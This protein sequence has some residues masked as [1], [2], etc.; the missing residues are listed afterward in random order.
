MYDPKTG[1]YTPYQTCFGSHHLQFGYDANETLW[2][3]GARDVAGWI[4]T[5]L[6]DETGDIKKAQGWSPF[7][8][9]TSGDGKRGE[10]TQP[11]K[12]EEPGK[13]KRIAGGFYAVMPSPVDGSVWGTFRGCPGSVVRFVPGAD[14]THTG[15]AEIYH[16]PMPG[17]GPRGGDIDKQGV[18]WVSLA[19]G[20]MGAFDRRK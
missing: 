14:P 6:L 17:F 19:S 9:D 16:V 7:I 13:D 18:V 20:H 5:K 3:S 1:K 10:Y 8:L 11:G 2:T 12:P 4:N 15:L